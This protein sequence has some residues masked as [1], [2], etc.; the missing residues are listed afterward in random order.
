MELLTLKQLR[1]LEE[2][3]LVIANFSNGFK[4]V[5]KIIEVGGTWLYTSSI[6]EIEIE[7]EE[8]HRE[9]LIENIGD[10]TIDIPLTYSEGTVNYV[11]KN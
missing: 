2:G 8:D 1:E 7:F 3:T 11:L 5:Q 6:D 9:T 10:D 4:E